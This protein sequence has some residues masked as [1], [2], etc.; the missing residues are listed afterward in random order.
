MN[1]AKMRM[2]CYRNRFEFRMRSYNGAPRFAS[3]LFAYPSCSA[4]RSASAASA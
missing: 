1:L 3:G 4:F 2:I